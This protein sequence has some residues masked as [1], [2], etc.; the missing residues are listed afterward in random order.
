MCRVSPTLNVATSESRRIRGVATM[1][2]RRNGMADCAQ[3]S[4]MKY[5]AWVTSIVFAIEELPRVGRSAA[6]RHSHSDG[7]GW[8]PRPPRAVGDP[9]LLAGQQDVSLVRL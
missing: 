6:R 4:G 7:A 2:A 1:F 3:I 9:A 5:W 8:R